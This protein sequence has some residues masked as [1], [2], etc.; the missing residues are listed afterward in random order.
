MRETGGRT[1]GVE[2]KKKKSGKQKVG[3]LNVASAG[4][5]EKKQTESGDRRKAGER[6]GEGPDAE[7]GRNPSTSDGE[8]LKTKNSAHKNLRVGTRH[9]QNRMDQK[10][11]KRVRVNR[12]DKKGGKGEAE[13]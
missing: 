6:C 12:N 7:Q 11:G 13:C 3:I 10:R 9:L 5:G 2:G 8:R 1:S 4:G